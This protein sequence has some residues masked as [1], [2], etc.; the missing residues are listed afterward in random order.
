[1]M[2]IKISSLAKA[3]SDAEKVLTMGVDELEY[4]RELIRNLSNVNSRHLKMASIQNIIYRVIIHDYFLPKLKDR[5]AAKEFVK[6][7]NSIV[8]ND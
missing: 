3:T 6:Q 5:E 8:E 4:G 1:M 7:V 2:L